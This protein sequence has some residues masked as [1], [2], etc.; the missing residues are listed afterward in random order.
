MTLKQKHF[1]LLEGSI[2]SGEIQ[3]IQRTKQWL[4]AYFSGE[5]PTIEHIPLRPFSPDASFSFARAYI[6]SF[7][8]ELAIHHYSDSDGYPTSVL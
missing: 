4:D 1:A 2:A 7:R 6:W 8:Q 5:N 3:I